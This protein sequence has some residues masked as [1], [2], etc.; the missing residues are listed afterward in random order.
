[1]KTEATKFRGIIAAMVTPFT[2][3][4]EINKKSTRELVNHLIESNIHGLFVISGAGEFSTLSFDEKRELLSIVVEEVAG[5]V[6]VYA[7]TGSVTTKETVELTQL[8][9]ELGADA[10]TV[11]A[12]YTVNPSEK[13]LYEHYRE[14]AK[15]TD[16]PVIVY[17]HPKITGVNL[18]ANL[19]AKLSKLDNVNGIKDSSGDLTLTMEY[20]SQ[21]DE[22]FSVLG[23][24]DKL[25]YPSLAC[26]AR[27]SISSTAGI[28]PELV[29]SINKYFRQGEHSKALEA[30]LA[31][32]PLRKTYDLGTYPAMI[33]QALNILGWDVGKCRPPVGEMSEE[34]KQK[35]REILKAIG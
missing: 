21:Q 4:Q 34:N 3:E 13:E 14:V 24:I 32:L 11:I 6:P 31:L 25:I 19:I 9:E 26:G 1:M 35:L 17:N 33:K 29:S 20:I 5:R 27:G 7:G 28:V 15:C 12:P 18:S 23:G 30:Q 8:A 16:L 2:K 22:G 10:V